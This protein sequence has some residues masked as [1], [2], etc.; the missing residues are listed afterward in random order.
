MVKLDG[1]QLCSVM[2]N[3]HLPGSRYGEYDVE[4]LR[5]CKKIEICD[6]EFGWGIFGTLDKRDTVYNNFYGG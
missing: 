3:R 1:H 6:G 5:C 4:F 2:R